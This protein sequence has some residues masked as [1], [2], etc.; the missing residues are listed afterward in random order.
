MNQEQ[1]IQ[2]IFVSGLPVY[3]CKNKL[4][5]IF[6]QFGEVKFVRIFS[7]KQGRKSQSFAKIKFENEE[8]VKKALKFSEKI[9]YEEKFITITELKSQ[10]KLEKSLQ[11]NKN[12][13]FVDNLPEKPKKHEIVN[14]LLYRGIPAKKV[15]RII[16]KKTMSTDN[17]LNSS[18]SSQYNMSYSTFS[19]GCIL[20]L[21]DNAKVSI[22]TL[23]HSSVT[24]Y[25]RVLQFSTYQYKNSE[26]NQK[27]VSTKAHSPNQVAFKPK[28]NF[29]VET[30]RNEGY[31]I[32]MRHAYK[33]TSHAYHMTHR[34]VESNSSQMNLRINKP[35]QN[36]RSRFSIQPQQRRR[37]Y[38]CYY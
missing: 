21:E 28:F 17:S 31:D 37:N 7:K 22:P 3:S 24:F 26:G 29:K 35:I 4:R 6:S 5:T 18:N 15:I 2:G 25:G 8:S 32:N 19:Y 9:T 38:R 33:P 10:S 20:Q 27:K 11:K 14:C 12:I 13:V 23:N 36:Q 34:F 30:T 16:K 1:S